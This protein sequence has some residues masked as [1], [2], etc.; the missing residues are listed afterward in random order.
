M[1]INVFEIFRSIQGESSFQGYPCIF[2]R[3]AG[4][5]LDCSWCDTPHVRNASGRPMEIDDIVSNLGFLGGSIVEVT[6]GEP[7]AQDNSIELLKRLSDKGYTVLLETSGAF[8]LDKVPSNVHIIMDVKGPS[9][10]MEKTLRKENFSILREKDE[11]KFPVATRD[12]FEYAL[13]IVREFD[14][15]FKKL[16]SPVSPGMEPSIL[17]K[18]LLEEGPPTMKLQLQLH[19]ILDMP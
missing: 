6:G 14:G 3:L 15:K 1:K 8:P 18:W 4:C 11:V 5:P 12:D 17:A 9:S 13:S 2:I 16:M 10:G 19:K 7:L